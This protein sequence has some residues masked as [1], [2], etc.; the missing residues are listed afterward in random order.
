[1]RQKIK[2]GAFIALGL[3][4]TLTIAAYIGRDSLLNHLAKEKIN[5]LEKEYGL[6]ISYQRLHMPGFTEVE[7]QQLSVVPSERD[8]LLTLKSMQ[9]DLSLWAMLTLDTDVNNIVTD[10]LHINFIKKDSLSN[11]DFLFKKKEEKDEEKGERNYARKVSKMLNMFFA[12]MP[13]NGQVTD[14]KLSHQ[15][16][17][18]YTE[19][20]IPRLDVKDNR[21]NT[22]LV[23]NDGGI[24]HHWLSRG[25]L[26][27]GDKT[28]KAELKAKSGGK[29]HLPYLTKH[30]GANVAFETLIYELTEK[31][32]GGGEVAL[33][34][35]AEVDG[36]ELFHKAL[37]PEVINLKSGRLDYNIRI[38]KDFFE[39]DSATVAQFNK[40]D[41]H[42]YFRAQKSDKWHITMGIEK[43][44]FTADDFFSSLPKGLFSNLD[45]LR[46]SGKLGYHFLLDIDF[47]NLNA[48]KIESDVKQEHFKI[49]GF[50][51]ENL[52]KMNS[53]FLYTAYEEGRPVRSFVVGSP[54]PNFRALDSI[55]PLLQMA[56]MQSE[57]GSFFS[58]RGFRL[59]ALRAALIYDLKCKK[60][61]RG[62][63][64][65]SMQ[66]VKNVFLNRNKNLLRKLEEA[67][68][69]WL[70][71]SQGI[72]SKHRMYEVYLNIAEWGPMIYGACEASHFY[73][74]KEP[75]QLSLEEA[76][77]MASIIPKPKRFRSSFD[78]NMQLRSNLGGYYRLIA[79]RL[80]RKGLITP[81]QAAG[82]QPV[83]TI[84]GAAKN[85]FVAPKDTLMVEPIIDEETKKESLTSQ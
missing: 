75:S 46:T 16:D 56:V 32:L 8:T 85:S 4:V 64:T 42:P 17:S 6:K 44:L 58:H 61:A 71:E 22:E 35:K 52:A 10:G 60:F 49:T 72:S 51:T 78:A 47:N 62:G 14:F 55:S 12:M 79:G 54:N 21:F 70:I 39:L 77:F 81:D 38:G 66:L 43:G 31:K 68:V 45:G 27:N 26:H 3:I 40:L 29:V 57:D 28:I 80:V 15:R 5:T 24:I 74:Q 84:T 2:I 73:F 33:I 18:A 65:I 30:Y 7:L 19:V 48:L 82:I 11:Y 83:V 50:G 69:V 13:Q 76:I 41:F 36:L 9:L 63:S 34:G 23:V 67:M 53:P 37:S 25:L 59:D 20:K 1:M